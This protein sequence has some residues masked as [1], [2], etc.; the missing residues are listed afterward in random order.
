VNNGLALNTP[1]NGLKSTLK[2]G[3]TPNT[4]SFKQSRKTLEIVSATAGANAD[5]AIASYDDNELTD[6]VNDGKQSTAWIKYTLREA[7]TV[8]EVTLKLNNFR[9][10]V[11]PIRIMVDDKEVFNGNTEKSLGY[12]TAKCKATKGKTVTIILTGAATTKDNANIGTEVAGQK[13]D[14][15][16]ARDDAKAK[17]TLSIIESEIYKSL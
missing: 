1:A 14:D 17:G 13:L 7:E 10:R 16:V 15:G 12:F 3:P 8:N 11:Y 9:S 2:R 5:K 6:W 4:P